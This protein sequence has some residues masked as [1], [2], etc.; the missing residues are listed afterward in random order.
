M[1]S[2]GSFD[3]FEFVAIDPLL[4]RRVADSENIRRFAWCQKSLRH[5]A[6]LHRGRQDNAAPVTASIRLYTFLCE[7]MA[8]EQAN[9]ATACPSSR[10]ARCVPAFFV[11]R[12]AR[13]TL[14][15][16]GRARIAR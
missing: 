16:R 10:C 13:R 8:A 11:L 4:Q 12:K 9:F 3:R 7:T 2:A 5:K 15:V 14:R 1:M 6:C